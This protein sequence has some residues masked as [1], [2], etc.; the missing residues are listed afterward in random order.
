MLAL[1]FAGE[2]AAQALINCTLEVTG[3]NGQKANVSKAK[4]NPG[5]SLCYEHSGTTDSAAWYF[6]GNDNQVCFMPNIG[7]TAAGSGTGTVEKCIGEPGTVA[8]HCEPAH[9]TPL[10]GDPL[11]VDDLSAGWY[12]WDAIGDPGANDAVVS[13]VGGGTI[14]GGNTSP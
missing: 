9:T 6:S 13:M 1:L 5:Q 7:G 10:D 8:N 14:E 2:A 12:Y 4:I 3:E 11:C